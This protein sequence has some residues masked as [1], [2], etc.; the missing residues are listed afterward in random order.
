[1]AVISDLSA[2]TFDMMID[3]LDIPSVQQGQ[4]VQITV[5]ALPGQTFTGYVDKININGV[6]ANGVTNYPVT[7]MVE[8]PDPA[9]LPGMNVSADILI[10]EVPH[11]L[12][13]PLS[14]VGRG[15]TV[16]V[17][18]ADAV[19]EKDGSID[20]SKAEE[21]QVTLGVNDDTYVEITDG[22]Q[23]GELVLIEQQAADQMTMQQVH[24]DMTGGM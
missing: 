5:D 24:D 6:T 4:K 21:R 16:K 15:N 18:P 22:L 2:L 13:V 19:S 8:D 7:V 23:E 11:A 20:V 10:E 12:T 14:A 3:E 17:L 1:M 9:L